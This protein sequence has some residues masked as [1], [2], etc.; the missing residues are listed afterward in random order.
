MDRHAPTGDGYPK[1]EGGEEIRTNADV[2]A[3]ARVIYRELQRTPRWSDKND[4]LI[5]EWGKVCAELN[6]R[7]LTDDVTPHEATQLRP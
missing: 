3:Y 2:I 1:R 7:G 4:A 5:R 6:A